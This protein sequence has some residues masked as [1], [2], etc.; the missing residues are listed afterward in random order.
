MADYKAVFTK[1]TDNKTI[2]VTRRFS[3]PLIKVWHAWTDSEI[4]DRWWAPKPYK[5]ETVAMDFREG[6]HWFYYMLS[7]EGER[8]YCKFNYSEIKPEEFYTGSDMFTDE[9]GNRMGDM[10]SMTWKVNFSAAEDETNLDILISFDKIE[11]METILKMGFQGGF[12]MGLGNLEEV[13][14]LS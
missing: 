14:A 11:D 10:P 3:A 8:H 2:T 5:A 13:L 6:G 9:N 7:P 12:T 1:D 4:L